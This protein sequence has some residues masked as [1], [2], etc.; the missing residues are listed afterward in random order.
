MLVAMPPGCIEDVVRRDQAKKREA[1]AAKIQNLQSTRNST[2]NGVATKEALLEALRRNENRNVDAKVVITNSSRKFGFDKSRLEVAV[3]SETHSHAAYTN[4]EIIGAAYFHFYSQGEHQL[5]EQRLQRYALEWFALLRKVSTCCTERIRRDDARTFVEIEQNKKYA[6]CLLENI[7]QNARGQFRRE[8][9]RRHS[10]AQYPQDL[11]FLGQ[12]HNETERCNAMA[13]ECW[14]KAVKKLRV[15]LPW[16]SCRLE[17]VADWTGTL[18]E[19]QIFFK[20]KVPRSQAVFCEVCCRGRLEPFEGSC[21]DPQ[22]GAPRPEYAVYSGPCGLTKNPCLHPRSFKYFEAVHS[23]KLDAMFDGECLLFSTKSDCA[24]SPVF[25]MSGADLDGDDFLIITQKDLLPRKD[26]KEV[27]ASQNFDD[28]GELKLPDYIDD[29]TMVHYFLEHSLYENTAELAT[30]HEAFSE[31]NEE[32]IGHSD[33]LTIAKFHSYALDFAKTGKAAEFPKSSGIPMLKEVMQRNHRIFPHYM[34]RPSEQSFHSKMI[35]GRFYDFVKSQIPQRLLSNNRFKKDSGLSGAVP[36]ADFD[37]PVIRRDDGADAN[38]ND[39]KGPWYGHYDANPLRSDFNHWGP[40]PQ[41]IERSAAFAQ[42]PNALHFR[43]FEHFNGKQ[44]VHPLAADAEITGD[45]HSIHIAEPLRHENVDSDVAAV[46]GAEVD[47]A[48]DPLEIYT[49]EST[50]EQLRAKLTDPDVLRFLK[51]PKQLGDAEI[52]AI[53]KQLDVFRMEAEDG[54]LAQYEAYHMSTVYA[55]ELQ[56]R[57]ECGSRQSEDSDN[58]NENEDEKQSV[59]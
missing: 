42:P 36:S 7:E 21:R 31:H 37:R 4:K 47:G 8:R 55:S 39:A 45:P 40:P 52:N 46:A 51:D 44:P 19:H 23:N 3:K 43:G 5:F 26:I 56:R 22:C 32:G 53:I 48:E 50:F 58:V 25:E 18:E 14:T 9:H 29:D 20:L 54:S 38:A 17:G 57:K 34:G 12:R 33:C 41:P 6:Q 1:I 59:E 27:V 11:Q 15:R 16:P 49:K 2:N 35:K 13:R 28:Q 24:N 30:M 10:R